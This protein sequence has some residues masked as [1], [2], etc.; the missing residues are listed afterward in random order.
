MRPAS[1]GRGAERARHPEVDQLDRPLERQQHVLRRD[2][3]VH[4]P[5]R[6]PVAVGQR[7]RIP[8]NGEQLSRKLD[9]DPDGYER[10]TA[11]GDV[12]W[13]CALYDRIMDQTRVI[14]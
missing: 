9:V 10:H 6:P 1:A 11:V 5:Q 8:L 12:R 2:V 14:A 4:D 13:V 3:A 7:V